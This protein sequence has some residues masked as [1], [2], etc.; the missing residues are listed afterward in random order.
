M[1]SE[2]VVT[3]DLRI[4]VGG[5][6]YRS[7]QPSRFQA[8]VS[9]ANGPTPGA[10]PVSVSGT[11]VNLSLLT[12]PGLCSVQNLDSTNYVTLGVYEPDTDMFYPVM[13]LLP[14]EVYV[15]R[16]ARFL[17]REST[18]TGTQVGYNAVLHLR[19]NAATA[20]VRVDAFEKGTT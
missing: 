18:G 5:I 19:A 7:P 3:S 15:I 14:G 20:W 13:E 12:T 11:D 1:A 9:L 4:N 10:F 6:Q 8:N 16:L 17:N 2:A